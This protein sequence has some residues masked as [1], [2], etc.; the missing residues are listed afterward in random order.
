MLHIYIEDCVNPLPDDYISRVDQYFDNNY[1]PEWFQD[2]FVRRIIQEIDHS[3]VVGEGLS[4][5]IYNEVLGN[6]PPQN[7]STGGKSLILLYAEQEIKTDGDRLGDNCI[8]ML[9][10]IA[11]KKDIFI[12]LSHVPPFPDEFEA[13]ILNNGKKINTIQEFLHEKIMI[14]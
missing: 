4:V 1:E 6:I 10:E 8:G 7:L 11:D 2:A 13:V 5:N 9:L 12:S 3:Q 14:Q